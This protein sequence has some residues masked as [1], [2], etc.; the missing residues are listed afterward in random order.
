MRQGGLET[1]RD[2]W[3]RIAILCRQRG[4]LR[5]YD[6]PYSNVLSMLLARVFFLLEWHLYVNHVKHVYDSIEMGR[7]FPQHHDFVLLILYP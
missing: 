1:D 4:F 3:L 2:A 5:R 7:I 6:T